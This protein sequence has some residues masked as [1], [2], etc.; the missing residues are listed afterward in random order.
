MGDG[1]E[2]NAAAL[3]GHADLVLT[4]MHVGMTLRGLWFAYAVPSKVRLYKASSVDGNE[5]ACVGG[6]PIMG[7]DG[8]AVGLWRLRRAEM[9]SVFKFFPP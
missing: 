5:I 9:H 6:E 1:R 8:G 2:P 4:G 3:A 7:G